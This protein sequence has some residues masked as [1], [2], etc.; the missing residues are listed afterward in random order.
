MLGVPYILMHMRGDPGTMQRREHTSYGDVCADVGRELQRSADAAC[1]SGIEP[2]RLVLDPGR[3]LAPGN[4]PCACTLPHSVNPG[5]GLSVNAW[6]LGSACLY[7]HLLWAAG[8]GFAKTGEGNCQLMA[9][10][11]RIRQQLAGPL[12]AA[13]LLVGPSRKG[14]LGKITGVWM[15]TLMYSCPHQC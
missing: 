8:I 4:A 7:R 3:V 14:F 11:A 5:R 9:G 15:R 10:L 1:S 6:L 13:P 2:W 12:H